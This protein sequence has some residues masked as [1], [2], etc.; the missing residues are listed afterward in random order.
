MPRLFVRR[1]REDNAQPQLA[2]GSDHPDM[3]SRIQ[4]YT[5]PPFAKHD[6][7]DRERFRRLDEP[8]MLRTS[9]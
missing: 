6:A 3:V 5:V 9:L 1:D 7:G 2:P 8:A 4:A